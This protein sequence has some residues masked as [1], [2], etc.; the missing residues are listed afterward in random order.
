MIKKILIIIVAILYLGIDLENAFSRL[1]TSP[2]NYFLQICPPCK[3]AVKRQEYYKKEFY[4]AGYNIG[5]EKGVLMRKS[6]K[7]YLPESTFKELDLASTLK[8]IKTKHTLPQEEKN[9]GNY[10]DYGWFAGF[11]DGYYG[12]TREIEY[13][14]YK[15]LSDVILNPNDLTIEELLKIYKEY[16]NSMWGEY[17]FFVSN[18]IYLYKYNSLGDM[19]LMT[20]YLDNLDGFI[21][22]F[23][24]D[25]S[26]GILYDKI[27]AIDHNKTQESSPE[28]LMA[29]SR[30]RNLKQ[31]LL[32]LCMP[33][34]YVLAYGHGLAESDKGNWAE[35]IR[36]CKIFESYENYDNNYWWQIN[37]NRTLFE[38]VYPM[39]ILAYWK[40]NEPNEEK[41][42]YEVADS[43][44]SSPAFNY[45]SKS[46][47]FWLGAIKGYANNAKRTGKAYDGSLIW[48]DESAKNLL[49]VWKVL[50]PT[51]KKRMQERRHK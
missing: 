44:M 7:D 5:Y 37:H 29:H 11:N 2:G 27:F 40:L 1:D 21:K 31:S 20:K 10:F 3:I 45:D 8:D 17:S 12:Y 24:E 46:R 13:I 42:I 14:F 26:A 49:E 25:H 36:T 30:T 18:L 32:I 19:K 22:R 47:Q 50:D 41:K 9:F 33:Y 15:K 23:P 38:I 4:G 16:P 43:R 28:V 34:K 48:D 6:G 51:V 39:M 35:V